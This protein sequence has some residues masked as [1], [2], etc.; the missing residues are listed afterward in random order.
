MYILTITL[1]SIVGVS[2]PV[3]LHGEPP[4]PYSSYGDCHKAG[5]QVQDWLTQDFIRVQFECR[6]VSHEEK[7]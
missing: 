4:T 5:E 6:E 2:H 7:G 3:V 1:Y